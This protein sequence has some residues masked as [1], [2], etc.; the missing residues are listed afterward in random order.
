MLREQM[1]QLDGIKEQLKSL[2]DGQVS[3]TDPDARSMATQ[4]N[5][6]GLVGYNVQTLSMPGTT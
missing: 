2:P 1:Q 6:S 5:G 3:L 4:A